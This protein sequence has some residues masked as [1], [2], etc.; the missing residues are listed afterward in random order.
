MRAKKGVGLCAPQIGVSLQVAV[1]EMDQD[2][3]SG[4]RVCVCKI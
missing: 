3:I 4:E 1:L 2:A